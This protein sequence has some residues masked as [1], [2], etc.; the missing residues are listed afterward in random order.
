MWGKVF[1][2]QVK[3]KL[4]YVFKHGYTI[5]RENAKKNIE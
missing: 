5:F 1:T 3:K 2:Y 4:D